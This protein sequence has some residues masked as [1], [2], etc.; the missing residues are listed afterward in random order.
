MRLDLLL[1]I[2]TCVYVI[3]RI[4]GRSFR[5]RPTGWSTIMYSVLFL[6][7]SYFTTVS[8]SYQHSQRAG[9]SYYCWAR[10]GC[11]HTEC[12][13]DI[14]IMSSSCFMLFLVFVATPSNSAIHELLDIDDLAATLQFQNKYRLNVAPD[15]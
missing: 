11:I 10:P 15:F 6:V 9:R 8:G 3:I 13:D 14:A 12:T 1:C 2:A 5:T 7:L 4:G